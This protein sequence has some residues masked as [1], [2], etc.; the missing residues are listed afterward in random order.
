[1]SHLCTSPE[2][3]AKMRAEFDPLVK[4]AGAYQSA[5]R[6]ELTYDQLRDMNYVTWV[7]HEALRFGATAAETNFY[8]FEQDTKIGSLTVKAY[9]ILMVNI[10]G[11]HHNAE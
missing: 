7:F 10:M 8:E 1:M 4:S 9:D 6:E 2:S 11:L 3:V 5:F